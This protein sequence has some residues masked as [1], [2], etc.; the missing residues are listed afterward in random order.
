MPFSAENG[1]TGTSS[2]MAEMK[3]RLTVLG[4]SGGSEED[5]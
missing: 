3:Q 5:A 2:G 4:E 1:M